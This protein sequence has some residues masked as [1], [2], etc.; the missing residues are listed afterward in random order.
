MED[1]N[2]P[3][4]KNTKDEEGVGPLQPENAIN[5]ADVSEEFP[6]EN[7]FVDITAMIRSLQRSEGDDD[8]FRRGSGDC[9]QL[10][11]NWRQYCLN[12]KD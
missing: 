9:D 3:I 10:N 8:C 12:N 1:F 6:P 4:T 11:C 2:K 5:K 7:R